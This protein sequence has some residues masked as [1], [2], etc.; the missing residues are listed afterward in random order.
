MDIV[1]FFEWNE[2]GSREKY[3]VNLESAGRLFSISGQIFLLQS[4]LQAMEIFFLQND[5]FYFHSKIKSLEHSKITQALIYHS[6]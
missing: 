2:D 3:D 1:R 6:E 5:T 4:N